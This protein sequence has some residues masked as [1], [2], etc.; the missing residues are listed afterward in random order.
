M[1][2]S[3]LRVLNAFGVTLNLM[4]LF[5]L[6]LALGMLVDNGIVVIENVYRLMQEG[7]SA[8]VAA[9]Q[10]VGEVAWPIITS[11]ATTLAAFLPLAF[12][13]DIIGEFMKFLPITLIIVLS[14]SLFVALVINPVL[15]AMYMKVVDPNKVKGKKKPLITAGAFAIFAI[16]FYVMG[17]LTMGN[18]LMLVAILTVFNTFVLIKALKWF[19]NVFLDNLENRY[20]QLLTW[21]LDKKKPYYVF[22]GTVL[23]LFL[24]LVL[25][26]VRAPK[27]LFFPDNEPNY[28]NIFIQKPIGTDI[29][30]T[31]DFT[32]EVETEMIEMMKPYDFMVDAIIAQVGEGTADPSEWVP[33]QGANYKSK[34]TISFVEYEK[35]QGV[36]TGKILEDIRQGY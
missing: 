32:M 13:Q 16:I 26:V 34:I 10:G 29:E 4:V 11:T 1:P 5:S 9:K 28:V 12:W 3:H 35:R 2:S 19:Q 20:S 22:F 33:S 7:K 24:S 15:A 31:N 25:L 30:A 14:S 18:L 27:V 21:S 6:I 23:L 17:S 36:S 8:I